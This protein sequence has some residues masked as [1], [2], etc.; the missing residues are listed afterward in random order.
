MPLSLLAK[1]G[2]AYAEIKG[3]TDL[4]EK[5]RAN[6]TPIRLR[7]YEGTSHSIPMTA[8]WEEIDPFLAQVVGR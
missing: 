5:L 6:G 2:P 4:A 8:Q 1:R 7:I 3:P